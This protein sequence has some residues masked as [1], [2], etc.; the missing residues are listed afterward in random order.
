MNTS[1]NGQGLISVIRDMQDIQTFRQHHWEGS[2]AEYLEVVRKNPKVARTAYQRLY[3]MIISYGHE[4]YTSFR[5]ERLHYRFFDDPVDGGADAVFGLDNHLMDLVQVFQSAARGYGTERR[6]LLLHGPVGSSKSTIVRLL[7]KGL[8]AYSA[9]D[10]G[11][12]YSLIWDTADGRMDCPMHEEPLRLIPFSARK[13]VCDDLNKQNT[14]EYRIT[15][16]GDL[17]PACRHVYRTLMEEYEGDWGK[18]IEHIR[19]RRIILSEKDRIGIGTFQ[20]KDEKN[21]DST[22]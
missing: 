10:E 1:T 9:T 21:Q 20:P 14:S 11:A 18:V 19:V 22:E 7:K 5:Q 3:D 12:L 17:C 6:V 4:P 15:I 16:E 13:K 2:F 8:E